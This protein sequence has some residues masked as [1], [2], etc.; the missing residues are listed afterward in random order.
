MQLN[1]S[2]KIKAKTCDPQRH[3]T[4]PNYGVY[5][6]HVANDVILS[7][8]FVTKVHGKL[9]ASSRTY[10]NAYLAPATKYRDRHDIENIASHKKYHRATH[11][12]KTIHQKRN[13]KHATRKSTKFHPITGYTIYLQYMTTH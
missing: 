8:Y 9:H 3:Q 11:T 2:S 1:C 5:I 6:T 12:T 13:Q 4:T 10:T 7:T